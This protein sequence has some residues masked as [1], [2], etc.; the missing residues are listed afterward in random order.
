MQFDCIR[1]LPFLILALIAAFGRCDP[2]DNEFNMT[3]AL[4]C[5]VKGSSIIG[6]DEE[7]PDYC[8]AFAYYM[9]NKTEYPNEL[10]PNKSHPK[11]CKTAETNADIPKGSALKDFVYVQ[12]TGMWAIV[13]WLENNPKKHKFSHIFYG[14]YLRKAATDNDHRGM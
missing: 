3:A 13:K 14:K 1:L 9:K 8:W 5:T 6:R 2:R 12:S 4:N 11:C 10:D 7:N